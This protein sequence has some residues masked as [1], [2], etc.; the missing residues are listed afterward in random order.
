M[1]QWHSEQV[2]SAGA[3][4]SL[5]FMLVFMFVLLLVLLAKF[6]RGLG[7]VGSK[8][9]SD[10]PAIGGGDRGARHVVIDHERGHLLDRYVRTER[11][12]TGP[13]H[14]LHG[15]VVSRFELLVPQQSQ[16]DP[17]LVHHDARV[18][19]DRPNPLADVADPLVERAGRNVLAG[20]V[21]GAR[22]LR[23][24]ALRREPG[25]DPV[26]LTG[27]VVVDLG[28]PEALEPPRGSWA[29]VSGRV[30]AIDDDRPGWIQA[31]PR[32][33]LDLGQGKVDRAREVL[34]LVLLSRQDLDQLSALGQ[35][36]LDLVPIDALR[37]QAIL[38]AKSIR[39]S[40]STWA[41]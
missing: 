41:G 4:A 7:R 21:P 1:P 39:K 9:Y 33:C 14:L 27:V 26:Q 35:E 34:V 2:R 23:I 13:Y 8:Q 5:G 11:A 15:L 24:P 28:E 18:P 19:I 20:H 17:L 3:S 40:S 32:I 37:H 6:E 29:Q 36:P 31:G 10:Q 12:G 25:G 22:A 16:H 30:P 38:P